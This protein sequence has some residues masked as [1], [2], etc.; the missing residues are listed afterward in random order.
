[1]SSSR[2]DTT[3]TTSHPSV[4][5]KTGATTRRPKPRPITP[6]PTV[7]VVPIARSSLDRRS[8]AAKVLL[9]GR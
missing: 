5:A 4:A 1:M 6:T 2:G 3:S 8:C 9:S 7:A